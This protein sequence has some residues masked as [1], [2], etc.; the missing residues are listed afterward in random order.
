MTGYFAL[1][2]LFMFFTDNTVLITF[3]VNILI[4]ILG[5]VYIRKCLQKDRTARG[6]LQIKAWYIPLALV[7]MVL[8]WFICQFAAT[9]IYNIGGTVVVKQYSQYAVASDLY[10]VLYII[11]SVIIAPITEEILMRGI[12]FGCI[13]KHNKLIAY[14][15]SVAVFVLMHRTLVHIPI[16]LLFG[17]VAAFVYDITGRLMYPIALHLTN[18]LL[19]TVLSDVKVD[20][21]FV[22]GPVVIVSYGVLLILTICFVV[23]YYRNSGQ[24]RKEGD[25]IK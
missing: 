18:N 16:T 10:A 7:F 20:S 8:Q 3:V 15:I 9:F 1:A 17:I 5:M 14:V 12:V 23:G 21:F 22:S 2:V 24:F 25:L 19:S 11:L 6:S 13:K 4:S